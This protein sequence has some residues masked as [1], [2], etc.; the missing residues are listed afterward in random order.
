[1]SSEDPHTI[2]ISWRTW[3]RLIRDLSRRGG[4]ERESGAFLLASR[5][6]P[7]RVIDWI[8]FDELD[9][10]ALNGAISIRGEAFVELWR[11]CAAR[12]LR[13]LA[14]VHTHPGTGV[15][16]SSID[17]ANPMVAKAGHIGIIVPHF[18]RRGARRRDIG[19]HVYRG[20]RTWA[21]HYGP[22]AARRLRLT[23]W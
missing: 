10:A 4:G 20:E 16:Q 14:D 11:T 6:R 2:A 7:R 19:F 12:G 21:S 9:P 3:R 23:W 17:Q 22:Q 15:E 5:R 18:A 8:P 1:M 13:V